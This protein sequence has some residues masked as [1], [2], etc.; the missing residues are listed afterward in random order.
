M[1]SAIGRAK[2]DSQADRV[3]LITRLIVIV[4]LTACSTALLYPAGSSA[5]FWRCSPTPFIT[6]IAVKNMYC[7]TAKR[8]IKDWYHRGQPMPARFRCRLQSG[9]KSRCRDGR[10]A[11]SFRFAE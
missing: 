3:A 10:K 6:D 11:F 8:Y 5:W 9:V 4:V 2:S 1:E 7:R